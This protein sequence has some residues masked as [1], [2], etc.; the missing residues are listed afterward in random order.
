MKKSG[1]CPKCR[2]TDIVTNE[3]QAKRSERS[4]LFYGWFGRLKL[5]MYLCLNCG[6]IEEHANLDDRQKADKLRENWKAHKLP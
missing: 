6:F 5:S 3:H 1:I 2:S 4:F